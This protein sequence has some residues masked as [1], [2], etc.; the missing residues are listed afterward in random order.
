MEDSVR[1]S[2]DILQALAGG[3]LGR[4]KERS[5]KLSRSDDS[6]TSRNAGSKTVLREGRQEG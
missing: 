4:R 1:G 3:T 5:N 2:D 6:Y